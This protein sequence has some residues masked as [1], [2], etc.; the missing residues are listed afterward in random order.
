MNLELFAL[1]AVK[2]L[3]HQHITFIY[4][5]QYGVESMLTVVDYTFRRHVLGF[6]SGC[7]IKH[8]MPSDFQEGGQTRGSHN[9]MLPD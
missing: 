8:H 4:R 1:I 2:F 9:T 6:L 5:G 7:K 3:A